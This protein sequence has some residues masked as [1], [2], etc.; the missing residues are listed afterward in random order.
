MPLARSAADTCSAVTCGHDR[1]RERIPTWSERNLRQRAGN[2]RFVKAKNDC[3]GGAG[4]DRCSAAAGGAE[5]VRDS[6][7][8]RIGIERRTSSDPPAPI[9]KSAWSPTPSDCL[10]FFNTSNSGGSV[11]SRSR[12]R[13]IQQKWMLRAFTPVFAG[14][15][16][17]PPNAPSTQKLARFPGGRYPL[18]LKAPAARVSPTGAPPAISVISFFRIASAKFS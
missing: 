8:E 13:R 4:T 11:V 10:W 5:N 15:G 3:R 14:Y 16:V 6:E 7:G 1:G 18:G 9:R 12:I 2:S 17:L